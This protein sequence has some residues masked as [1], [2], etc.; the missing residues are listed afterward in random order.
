[1][2]TSPPPEEPQDAVVPLVEDEE[3]TI[4]W[5]PEDWIGIALFWV[6]AL[7]VFAQFVTRYLLND[8]LS[9]TEEIA[10]YFLMVLTFVGAVTVTRKRAHIAVEVLEYYLP[11]LSGRML[12]FVVD[13]LTVGFIGLLAWFSLAIIERM[14]IQRMTMIDASMSWVYAPISIAIFA[15]L[16]RAVMVLI[17]NARRG[18]RPRADAERT[19][20]D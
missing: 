7:I 14:Q 19:V 9:W 11:G 17:G 20:I 10:R 15:M 12:R 3:V 5:H 2:P 6:L 8:S 13:V 16:L 4:S 18:W 1:M